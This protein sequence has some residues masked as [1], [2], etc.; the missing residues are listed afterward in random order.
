MLNKLLTFRN[1]TGFFL[2]FNTKKPKQEGPGPLPTALRSHLS[3]R[4]GH[5]M[6]L[7]EDPLQVGNIHLKE[8]PLPLLQN[9]PFVT[10][11]GGKKKRLP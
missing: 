4:S 3:E 11:K 9:Y 1:V 7:R 10:K 5:E 6:D 2:N 8:Q